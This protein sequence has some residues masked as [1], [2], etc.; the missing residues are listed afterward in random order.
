VKAGSHYLTHA[1]WGCLD[2]DHRAWITVE[3]E[4]DADARRMVP[5]VIRS[6]TKVVRLFQFTPEHVRFLQQLTPEQFRR[7]QKLPVEQLRELSGLTL[8]QLSHFLSL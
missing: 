3:A 7:L 2:G 8:E 4:D 5:P 1:E 6:S